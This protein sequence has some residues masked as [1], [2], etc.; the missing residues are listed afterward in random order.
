MAGDAAGR[1]GHPGARRSSSGRLTGAARAVPFLL[2]S[3]SMNAP[4]AE[5]NVDRPADASPGRRSFGIVPGLVWAFRIHDDGS[6]D[7]LPVDLAAE[8]R[9][10]GWLWL[11]VDLADVRAAQWLAAAE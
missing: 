5:L 10:D 4:V 9:H 3:C 11:H 6:A 2:A 7:P 1:V 8:P